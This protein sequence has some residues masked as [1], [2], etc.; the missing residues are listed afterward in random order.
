M[1][2][3]SL[4]I[5]SVFSL[6]AV[7]QPSIFSAQNESVKSW[8]QIVGANYS[9]SIEALSIKT[10][11]NGGW[12]RVSIELGYVVPENSNVIISIWPD[13]RGL[14]GGGPLM[15][16]VWLDP[17]GHRV[18]LSFDVPPRGPVF[19]M[20]IWDGLRLGSPSG[21]VTDVRMFDLRPK[22]FHVQ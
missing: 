12:N 16:R 22:P 9:I 3:R 15:G 6:F 13:P 8:R 11:S 21:V 18:T 1:S 17:S 10:G 20:E 7:C 19:Y 14:R 4:F 2:G 5:F